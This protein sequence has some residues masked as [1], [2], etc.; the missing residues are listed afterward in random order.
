MDTRI[1]YA[2]MEAF[3]QQDQITLSAEEIRVLGC[4]IEKSLTTPQ[5]YPLTLN[6]LV[7]ACNQSTNRHPVVS[8]S[9]ELTEKTLQGMKERGL[10]RF[11]YPS[12]GRSAT[13]Y[14]HIAGEKFGL[15]TPELAVITVLMLR[16]PQTAGELRARTE[17]MYRFND[18]SEIER[19]LELISSR[20]NRLVYRLPRQPGTKEDRW[21]FCGNEHSANQSSMPSVYQDGTESRTGMDGAGGIDD[22]GSA[23]GA[24]SMAA[25]LVATDTAGEA[26]TD[27]VGTTDTKATSTEVLYTKEEAGVLLEQ[28]AA[29]VASIR[30]DLDEV[31]SALGLI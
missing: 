7:L 28:L 1:R 22:T 4:L 2:S 26:P 23:G 29:Q 21:V 31:R 9:D 8:Y 6:A 25:S 14:R 20:P 17:R 15:D 10:V 27:T 13:R 24:D 30:H 11:V 16:G 3:I 12:H 18:I 19:L 5:Q